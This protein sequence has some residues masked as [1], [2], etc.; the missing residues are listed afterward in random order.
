MSANTTSG[1][2]KRRQSVRLANDGSERTRFADRAH[3]SESG[4]EEGC[5]GGGSS[6]KGHAHRALP[7][8]RRRVHSDLPR[9]LRTLSAKRSGRRDGGRPSEARVR[10]D[11][12]SRKTKNALAQRRNALCA[13]ARVPAPRASAWPPRARRALRKAPETHRGPWPSNCEGGSTRTRC[14]VHKCIA[15]FLRRQTTAKSRDKDIEPQRRGDEEAK[16]CQTAHSPARESSK[17][18]QAEEHRG[19]RLHAPRCGQ[20]ATVARTST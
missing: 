20:R 2:H 19:R 1:L 7:G 9:R 5:V 12:A 3:A 14:H 13:M 17:T 6:R 10:V 11:T 18:Q 15:A 8:T 4:K 16:P